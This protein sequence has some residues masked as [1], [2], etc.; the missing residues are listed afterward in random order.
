MQTMP[1][2]L[3]LLHPSLEAVEALLQPRL[4]LRQGSQGIIRAMFKDNLGCGSMDA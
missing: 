3:Q 4:L 2:R 1:L